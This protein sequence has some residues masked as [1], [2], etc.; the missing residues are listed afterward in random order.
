MSTTA[1]I[2]EKL[3]ALEP[4]HLEV[5]DDSA[6]HAGHAGARDGGGHYRVLIVSPRFADLATMA[7][8]RL[9]YDALGKLMDGAIHALSI[10]A[11]TPSEFTR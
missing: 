3:A 5:I 4:T 8:H 7:R 1:A 6:A 9:V 2:R 10:T 11:R